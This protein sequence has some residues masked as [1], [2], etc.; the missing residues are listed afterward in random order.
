MPRKRGNGEGTIFYS[1]SSKRWIGQFV[2]GL[3][4]NGTLNR[5]TVYG[6]SQKEVK[7]KI[8]KKLSEVKTDTFVEKTNITLEDIILQTI[9]DKLRFNKIS[10]STYVRYMG[11]LKQIKENP[12]L[13]Y[14]MPIRKLT[15]QRLKSFFANT[16][17]Y[18]NSVI[19]KI[20]M[21]IN[22]AFKTA[23]RRKFI[24]ENPMEIGEI[25]RPKSD[26]PDKKVEAITIEEQ[27]KLQDL[28][29]LSEREHPYRNA[30]LL[31]LYTGMRAGEA[32][33]L[34]KY[35]DIDLIN[36]KIHIRRSL[37][38][39]KNEKCVLGKTTKTY[40]SSR[41]LDFTKN[42]ETVICWIF[43]DWQ[44]NPENLLFWD[45]ENDEVISPSEVT[46]YLNR[47]NK[48]YGIA[49]HLHCHMLRHT[50]ATR[51]IEAGMPAVVLQKKLGHKDITI[52]LNTYTSVFDKFIDTCDAKCNE[53][54]SQHNLALA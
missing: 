11:T 27:Q 39:D 16:T 46:S 10:D 50:Y 6:K 37:T 23:I 7:E 2:A 43:N 47:L 34:D 18:S 42:I 30:I 38:I 49:E 44:P 25:P 20:Y 12:V 19:A 40:N 28:L 51:S 31:M 35:K 52:T 36:K 48:S 13:I 14:N 9:E 54:L 41:T 1:E 26:N 15:I 17:H 24:N 5:K 53:Y 4:D 33:A 29:I 21:L 32:L 8:Q 22:G 3:K 45:Y